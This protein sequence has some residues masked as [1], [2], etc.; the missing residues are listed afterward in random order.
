MD[1][2]GKKMS[3]PVARKATMFQRAVLEGRRRKQPSPRGTDAAA[4]HDG[5]R[6]GTRNGNA[7]TKSKG[8]KAQQMKIEAAFGG[9]DAA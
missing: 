1:E 7:D 8:V 5:V 2:D 9:A 6:D 4:R 3:G